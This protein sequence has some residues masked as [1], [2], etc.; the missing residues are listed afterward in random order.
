MTTWLKWQCDR[1]NRWLTPANS[2]IHEEAHGEPCNYRGCKDDHTISAKGETQDRT[3]AGN[4][5]F[6]VRIK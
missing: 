3:D 5:I 1:G 4:W 2:L 6:D